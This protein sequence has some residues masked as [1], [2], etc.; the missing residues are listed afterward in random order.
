MTQSETSNWSSTPLSTDSNQLTIIIFKLF[1]DFN[2]FNFRKTWE[3]ATIKSEKEA[4]SIKST[5][6]FSLRI[7]P[8]THQHGSEFTLAQFAPHCNIFRVDFFQTL[9]GGTYWS[10]S[11]NW[12][13]RSG[14][15]RVFLK[16]YSVSVL[17]FCI[18]YMTW[19]AGC[20]AF[21]CRL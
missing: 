9:I 12:R 17:C 3:R 21:Q 13:K 8:Y 20:I 18:W 4:A 5:Y 19:K 11:K 15:S 14:R 1:L 16:T 10:F 2:H 6:F 7:G